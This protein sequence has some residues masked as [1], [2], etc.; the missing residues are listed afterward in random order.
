MPAAGE[1]V[2]LSEVRYGQL[3]AAPD[4]PAQGEQAP[5]FELT[6]HLGETTRLS[7]VLAEGPVVLMFYRGFW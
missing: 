2:A 6:N 5:D 4:A 7:D 1:Y 3:D